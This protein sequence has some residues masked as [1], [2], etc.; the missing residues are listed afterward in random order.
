MSDFQ[1]SRIFNLDEVDNDGLMK[2]RIP[3]KAQS[4]SLN[5]QVRIGGKECKDEVTKSGEGLF[6]M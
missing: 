3:E 1:T 5:V 6:V 4:R 2:I